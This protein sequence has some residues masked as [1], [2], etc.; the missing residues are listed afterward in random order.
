MNAQLLITALV[1]QTTV[2]IAQVATASGGRTPL[3]HV[4]NQVFL[5][6]VTELERQGLGRKVIADM[7]G[8]ALRS[9][10]QK[11]HRLSES[12][13]DRGISLWEAMHRFLVDQEVSSRSEVLQRFAKDDQGTVRGILND[14]VESGLVYRTGRGDSTVYRIA[15]QEDLERAAEGHAQA[16]AESMAWVVVYRNGPV[17]RAELGELL[18]IDAAELD[19]ALERL[20]ADGRIARGDDPTGPIYSCDRCYLPLGEDAGWEAALLDHYQ[21]VVAAVCQ[22]LRNGSTRSLPA[23]QVGGSTFSFDVWPGH[24]L[25][26]RV[27]GLLASHRRDLGRL[28]DE[29]TAHNARGKPA[30]FSKVTFYLGQFVKTDEE[31]ETTHEK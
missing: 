31:E 20:V 9:Y 16:T 8:L 6:L 22:K 21:A 28:W 3:S 18:P 12:A 27:T 1:R 2:L 11:V 5:D 23:D 26:E 17:A 29:V 14:L 10:Q 15:P 13:T 25:E 24:P 4:A 7:F 30:R 19:A